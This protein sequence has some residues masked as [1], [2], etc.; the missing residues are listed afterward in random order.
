MS[1][2]KVSHQPRA[3]KMTK[4]QAAQRL[5]QLAEESMTRK[6]FSEDKKNARVQ[7]FVE[8]VDTISENRAK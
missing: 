7:S 5:A 8:A 3:Q 2:A 6:G 4:Q 1:T